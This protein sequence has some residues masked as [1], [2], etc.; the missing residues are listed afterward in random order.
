MPRS[1]PPTAHFLPRSSGSLTCSQETKNASASKCIMLVSAICTSLHRTHSFE[2]VCV[3]SEIGFDLLENGAREGLV[4]N[5]DCHPSHVIGSS[6]H[7]KCNRRILQCSSDNRSEE[8][9][10]ELQ[11]LRHL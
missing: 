2:N 9:T 1:S 11:S 7:F 4:S 8:H 10:S 6:G 5:K 3:G